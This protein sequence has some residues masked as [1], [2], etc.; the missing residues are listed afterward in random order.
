MW[1]RVHNSIP[2]ILRSRE[3][4]SRRIDGPDSDRPSIL[5]DARKCALLRMTGQRV[6]R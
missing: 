4:A 1:D 6:S 3:A 2:V 5:R